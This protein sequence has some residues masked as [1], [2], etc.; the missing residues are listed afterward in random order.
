MN[1]RHLLLAFLLASTP[2]AHAQ[3]QSFG[4]APIEITSEGET[5]FL[6]G[7]AIAENNV[8]I[9][10]G[11]TSAYAD[12]AQYNPDTREV[13]LIGNVRILK[14]GDLFVGDR[15]LYNLET[16]LL[17]TS[18]FRGTSVPFYLQAKS[19]NT[20]GDNAYE[21]KNASVTTSDSSK[22][23]YRLKAKTIRIYPGDRVDMSNVQLFVGNTPLFWF[24]YYSQ[25][26]NE[27][28]SFVATPGYLSK[29]GPYILSK[30]TFPVNQKIQGVVLLDYREKRG[31]AIGLDATGKYGRKGKSWFELKSYYL[32]DSSTD[33]NPTANTRQKIDSE[34]YRVSFQ[35]KTFFTEDIYANINFNKLS[36]QYFLRD[37]RPGEFSLNPQPDNLF[38]LTKKDDN[39]TLTGLTRF[40][41]NPFPD[42]GTTERLPEVVLDVKRQPF[43]NTP[44]FYEG[45]TGAAQLRRNFQNTKFFDFEA[46]R[47]DTFHQFTLPQTFDNWL[48]FV[49]RIGFRGTYYS[50]GANTLN[51]TA[52]SPETALALGLNENG[53]RALRQRSNGDSIFRP[54]FNA[55]FESSFKISREWE[56]AQSRAL[57]LDGLRH[58]IQPYTNFSFVRT[59]E[60]AVDILQFDRL[61]PSTQLPSLDFPQFNAIDSITDW[62][63]I[64][65]GVRNRLQTRRDERTINWL[66]LDTYFNLNLDKPTFPNYQVTEQFSN[67]Y[68]SLAF[69]PFQWGSLTVDTQ[70]PVFNKGFTQINTSLNYLPI[71]DL[72]LSISHRYIDENPYFENSST[73]NLG[74]YLRLDDNWGFS[75]SQDY[76]LDSS[77]LKSQQY[78]IYRDLSTWTAAFIVNLRENKNSN[79]G[80]SV[81]DVGVALTFTLKDLPSL[82]LPLSYEP[83]N[84]SR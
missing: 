16:K 80:K 13:L 46:T 34:R 8:V 33:A 74:G 21:A 12:Y 41:I 48:S 20:L 23:D 44:I 49:P 38:S 67:L 55:G 11:T 83:S 4:D 10:Y 36:D 25:S 65:L 29:W 53:V 72:R 54:V 75:F 73:L 22:P 31:A 64:R 24:P 50:K 84:D 62:S 77:L 19:I 60:D 3:L 70:L 68:T 42:F 71:D 18:E 63:I 2:I 66:E 5:R 45:E 51:S 30:W 78:G 1:I 9:H 39:Y 32:Q 81:T 56:G 52:I 57:G 37:F 27:N 28:Q 26:L 79:T 6:G 59:N 43:F 82:N 76:E 7:V 15:A 14:D 40:E 69:N 61:N 17:T 58:V 35:A 47:F